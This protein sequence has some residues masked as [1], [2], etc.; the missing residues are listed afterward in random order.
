MG[1]QIAD[2]DGKIVIRIHQSCGGRHNTVTIGVRIV[3]ECDAVF[4]IESGVA[5]HREWARTGHAN[6]TYV[7]DHH[8]RERWV[9]GRVDDGN[10]QMVFGVDRLPVGPGSTSKWVYAELE[11]RAPNCID[12]DNVSQ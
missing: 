6:D 1:K 5:G 9:E 3:R 7:I 12:V 11:A 8:E 2:G 4:V 10:V